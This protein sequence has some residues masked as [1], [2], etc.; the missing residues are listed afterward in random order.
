MRSMQHKN[1]II[2]RGKI[3]VLFDNKRFVIKT[4]NLKY[5]SLSE[6]DAMSFFSCLLMSF[7]CHQQAWKMTCMQSKE[8]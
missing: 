2:S 4:D 7:L 6:S 5:R 8:N 3:N 1:M